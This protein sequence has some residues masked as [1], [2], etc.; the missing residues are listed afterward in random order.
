MNLN[1]P[2]RAFFEMDEECHLIEEVVVDDDAHGQ[3]RG[4]LSL[5]ISFFEREQRMAFNF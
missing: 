5:G 1:R 2:K 4:A 3:E